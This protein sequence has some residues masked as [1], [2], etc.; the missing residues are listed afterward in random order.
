MKTFE[1]SPI[2][3]RKSFYRKAIVREENGETI[4]RSYDT[5]VCKID[6][7]GN[8]VRMWNGYSATTMNHV[9]SFLNY[10]G[11]EGGGKKFWDDQ[12]VIQ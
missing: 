10:V 11:I 7:N 2:N 1:L 6:I 3:G 5:D 9:N 12:P 8:F 4:L